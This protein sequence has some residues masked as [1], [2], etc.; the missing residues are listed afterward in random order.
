MFAFFWKEKFCAI[1]TPVTGWIASAFRYV[2]FKLEEKNPNGW[3]SFFFD[4]LTFAL[5]SC[6]FCF[7]AQFMLW[8][9]IFYLHYNWL[10]IIMSIG[11]T[12]TFAGITKQIT[13]KVL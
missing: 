10:Q 13:Y 1:E 3:T 9:G 4:K 6:E 5:F 11:V 2:N 8:T 7:G 12:M